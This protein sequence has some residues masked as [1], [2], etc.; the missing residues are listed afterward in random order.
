MPNTKLFHRIKLEDRLVMEEAGAK[1]ISE[2]T[3]WACIWN[4]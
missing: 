1:K 2:F 3:W 4:G